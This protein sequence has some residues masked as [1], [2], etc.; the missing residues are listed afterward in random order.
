[1]ALTNVAE[2]LQRQYN[3]ECSRTGPL[4]IINDPRIL[5]HTELGKKIRKQH[6]Y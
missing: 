6:L 1:M 5:A 4:K 3:K 2:Q